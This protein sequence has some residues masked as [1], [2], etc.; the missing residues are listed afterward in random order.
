MAKSYKN[1][2]WNFGL[3][4]LDASHQVGDNYLTVAKDVA[5]GEGYVESREGYSLYN[6]WGED[7]SKTG[8][9]TMMTPAYFRDGTKQLVF[10]NADHYYNIVP[11]S[12]T[13]T[14]WT[15]LGDYG[16]E[17]SNPF[18]YMYKD[19]IE[20]GTGHASN[21]QKKYDGTT[22]SDVGTPADADS[23]I[24]FQEYH[25]GQNLAYLLAGGS[26]T[27]SDAKN[28]STMFAS[29]DPDD[30]SADIIQIGGNDGQNLTAIKSHSDIIAYKD[31]SSYRM[32][33]ILEP[34]TSTAILRV[35][36]RFSDNGSIN[37][38]VC[39]VVLNDIISLSSRH[40]VRGFQ[41]T[42]T[43]LGGSE[44]KRYS[45]KIKPLLN[46]INWSVAKYTAR[47]I[48]W[49]EKYY[50]SVPIGSSTSNN[51]VFVGHLDSITDIGE[52]PWTLFSMNIGSFA[53]FQDE[54]GNEIFLGGDSNQPRIYNMNSGLSDN[55]VEIY[56]QIK[57]KKIDMGDLEDDVFKHVIIAG[58]MSEPTN[59][60]VK[61]NVDGME[62]PYVIK[63]EQ[64]LQATSPIWSYTIGSEIIGGNSTEITYPRYIAVLHLPDGLRS[65][66]EMQIDISSRGIGQKW[67]VDYLS[68]N[69]NINLTKFSDNHNVNAL[70]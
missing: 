38:E 9:I 16:T 64:L 35:L 57:T 28:N 63:K 18:A 37:H 58:Q 67:R 23:D 70:N 48:V 34:S 36:D 44:S 69:E 12:D 24:R 2:N 4:V 54:D 13:D 46:Q 50:L 8:G 66:A 45:T 56:S 59:I 10:A 11:N 30:Y 68:I 7:N 5:V 15:D 22:L 32:D 3:N 14:A 52:I 19:Y 26:V 31:N 60:K 25:Q 20:F 33:V 62:T 27:D 49:N 17:V 29:D 6:G 53:I 55:G 47:S 43:K 40:G 41:Q 65:G 51:A 61:I 1:R 21:N 39:Q 42:Q